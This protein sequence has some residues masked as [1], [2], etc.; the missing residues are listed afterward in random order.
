MKWDA[1]LVYYKDCVVE[2]RLQNQ[3]D[4]KISTSSYAVALVAQR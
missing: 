4:C 3:Q 1:I 2:D